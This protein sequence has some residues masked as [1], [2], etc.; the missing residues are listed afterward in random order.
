[1]PRKPAIEETLPDH[2]RGKAGSVYVPVP[3]RVQRALDLLRPK[4]Q[5]GK[6]GEVRKYRPGYN[7]NEVK[8]R[9]MREFDIG[10]TAAEGDL[11]K[12]Y[13]VLRAEIAKTDYPTTIRTEM[14]AL[15]RQASQAGDHASAGA[16]WA[17]LG[18]WSGMEGDGEA[19]TLGK[20]AD[21]ALEAAIKQA[22]ESEVVG[23][24]EERFAALVAKRA[25]KAGAK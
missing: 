13:E 23:M 17:R 11:A 18:K 1:M 4:R 24:D 16:A 3:H 7:Y 10:E 12:A 5:R 25:E 22:V 19:G 21:A 20:L 9:L 6:E 8:S 2:S 14:E 15:A